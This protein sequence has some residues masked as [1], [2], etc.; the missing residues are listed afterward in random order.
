MEVVNELK[1]LMTTNSRLMETYVEKNY[2][3]ITIIYSNQVKMY[4]V[5]RKFTSYAFRFCILPFLRH[6]RYIRL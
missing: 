6:Q 4:D 3:I 2:R 5:E 1:M